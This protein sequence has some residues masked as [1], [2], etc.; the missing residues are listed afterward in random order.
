LGASDGFINSEIGNSE[1]N[2][3]SDTEKQTEGCIEDM[4]WQ[5]LGYDVESKGS[6]I[7]RIQDKARKWLHEWNSSKWKQQGR[8]N[9]IQISVQA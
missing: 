4:A 1:D 2:A 5:L 7:S 6:S 9:D 8:E 3:N